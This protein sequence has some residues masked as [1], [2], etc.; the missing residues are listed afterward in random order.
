MIKGQLPV[1]ENGKVYND[2]QNLAIAK[3]EWRLRTLSNGR[4]AH[5][6][7][8]APTKAKAVED[9]IKCGYIYCR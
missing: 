5:V 3:T 1:N 4:I 7:V 6:D 8:V 2:G 9:M